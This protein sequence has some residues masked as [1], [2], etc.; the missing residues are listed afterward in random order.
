MSTFHMTWGLMSSATELKAKFSLGQN[1][2]YCWGKIV[3]SR[4]KKKRK[5][6]KYSLQLLMKHCF[7]AV[8]P[9]LC[10]LRLGT[11]KTFLMEILVPPPF[12][13]VRVCVHRL[14][15]FSL[16]FLFF[17]PLSPV[18]TLSPQDILNSGLKRLFLLPWLS[19]PSPGW[20]SVY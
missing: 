18:S 11:E 20:L 5:K 7:T 15:S 6:I 13:T 8:I 12:F 19:A 3:S 17:P 10:E 14:C 2:K 1:K 16:F 9:S 4:V